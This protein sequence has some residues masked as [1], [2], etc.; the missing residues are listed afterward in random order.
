MS[1]CGKYVSGHALCLLVGGFSVCLSLVVPLSGILCACL[2]GYSVSVCG[3]YVSVGG[4]FLCPCLWGFS[5]FVCGIASVCASAGIP[6]FGLW[7]P[8]VPVCRGSPYLNV[9]TLHVCFLINFVLKMKQICFQ[10]FRAGLAY[11][12]RGTG[13]AREALEH[14]GEGSKGVIIKTEPI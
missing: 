11:F 10:S 14:E 3:E 9:G 5:E 4:A 13:K 7:A 1:V 8:S 2:W 12:P 6:W